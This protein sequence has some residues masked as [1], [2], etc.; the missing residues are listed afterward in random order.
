MWTSPVVSMTHGTLALTLFVLPQSSEQGVQTDCGIET[1][2]DI[3][4]RF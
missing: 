1:T 4:I 2:E 3:S